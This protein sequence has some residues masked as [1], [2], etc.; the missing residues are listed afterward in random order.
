MKRHRLV[1]ALV[2]L[3]AGSANAA[4]FRSL[5]DGTSLEGWKALDMSYWSVRDEAIT[6]QS[7]AEHPCRSN[8]FIVWQGGEVA[9]FE[10]KL[11]FRVTGNGCNSGV[12][13]RSVIR[14]DG[15]A[16]GYQADIYQSGS[17]LGGVCDELHTRQGPELLTA[18]GT[19]TVID[20]SG[21]REATQLGEACTMKPA[22]EWNDYHITA[23]GQHVIL[24]M[25]GVTCSELIDQEDGHFDLKGILA[26]QLRSGEPMTVQF[27]DIFLK[28]LLPRG[29]AA[30]AAR[31]IARMAGT[32][33]AGGGRHLFGSTNYGRSDL[34]YI[35]ARQPGS[36]GAAG[37]VSVM[38]AQ[39][40]IGHEVGQ[41]LFL[42]LL[43]RDH[44]LMPSPCPIEIALNDVVL[45]AGPN[46]FPNDGFAW[47]VYE[48]PAEAV[49][50]GENR[51]RITNLVPEGP[52][53]M[54][55]WFTLVQCGV[56]ASRREL[57][58]APS[59][60]DEFSVSI[61]D[62]EMPFPEPLPEG[63]SPGF[64]LRGT[65]GWNWTADRYLATIDTLVQGKM[66]FLMICPGS[67]CDIENV[68]WDAPGRN[69]WWE[70]LPEQKKKAYEQVVRA[71]QENGIEFCLSVNPIFGSER[72]IDYTNADD[73]NAL[74][75]HYDW[76]QSL[77]VR[78]FG[79]TFDDITTGIDAAGQARVANA[80]LERLRA[81]DPKANLIICPCFYW[82]DGQDPAAAAYLDI[83]AEQLHPD[84]FAFW[85]GD[86]A[87]KAG[88]SRR[89]AESYKN[90]IRHR[91]IIWDNYPVNDARPT[92]HLGPLTG[93]DPDL[94]EV[95]YGYMSNP[96]CTEVEANRIPLLTCA[97]YAW[98]PLDYDPARSI[99]QA[100]LRVSQTAEQRA[101]LR[102]LVELYPGM[103]LYD[104]GVAW[105]PVLERMQALMAM[106]HARHL[107][108]LYLGYVEDVARRLERAFPG[109][110]VA[111]RATMAGH[112]AAMHDTYRT[113]YG[114][115]VNP[116][117]Q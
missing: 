9:D 59:L 99:G 97:D 53:G 102:D 32:D 85:T 16:I 6:G 3:L 83:L 34:N 62:E 24:R 80:F 106:Q 78:W 30:A 28:T 98:N 36:D 23:R 35:Y 25:N 12:Q 4:E 96:M 19:K 43:G 66:N 48:I 84:V 61:P 13:F 112:I 79:L 40:R 64:T 26:L 22:G 18:N 109:R 70:P 87:V 114:E 108:R 44:D 72:P 60:L 89:G 15:L 21:H 115:T 27:K 31:P 104:K 38:T 49:R 56:S 2:V 1:I 37:D 77:G 45:F 92:M 116:E 41:P 14:P 11:K 33:F 68:H 111:E 88:I 75:Q 76:M 82:G 74:W 50:V 113:K 10:L 100:I 105:N 52:I 101:V 58:D 94:G 90:R 57:P 46:E 107:P 63:E 47:R 67:M 55:P 8:Q 81:R 54:P 5:F 42:H 93:R 71:C 73:L 20:A 51:I 39:F 103:L 91:L 17:Y 69:R 7:T 117:G 65:K 95:C 86:S 110:Y 29:R